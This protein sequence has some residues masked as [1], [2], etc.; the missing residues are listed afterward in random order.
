MVSYSYGIAVYICTSNTAQNDIGNYLGLHITAEARSETVLQKRDPNLKINVRSGNPATGDC[1]YHP[2]TILT[3]R[4]NS[5]NK[6]A[7]HLGN[8]DFVIT[9][10]PSLPKARHT[11]A[12]YTPSATHTTQTCQIPKACGPLCSRPFIPCQA[13]ALL[14]QGQRKAVKVAAVATDTEVAASHVGV[15]LK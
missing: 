9:R 11:Q 4:A 12:R 2:H 15:L 14:V 5:K 7:P 6:K 10:G 1:D 13:R 8:L 3:D